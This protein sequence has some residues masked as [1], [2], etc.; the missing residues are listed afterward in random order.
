MIGLSSECHRQRDPMLSKGVLQAAVIFDHRSNSIGSLL[1]NAILFFDLEV[2]H[3]MG[4]MKV[5]RQAPPLYRFHQCAP[6]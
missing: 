2:I 3:P 4:L 5:D 6:E 1:D